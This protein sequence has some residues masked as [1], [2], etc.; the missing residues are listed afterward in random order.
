MYKLLS[1][2]FLISSQISFAAF[3]IVTEIATISPE[4]IIAIDTPQKLKK[5]IGPIHQAAMIYL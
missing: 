4:S 2:I 5:T 1:F 3:P